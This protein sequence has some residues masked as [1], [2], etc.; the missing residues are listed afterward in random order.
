VWNEDWTASL[1]DQGRHVIKAQGARAGVELALTE[2]KAPAINGIDGISQKGA[3]AGNASHYYSLTRMP[4]RGS[5]S[6][7]GERFEIAGELDGPR[8]RHEL[9]GAGPARMG[10]AVDSAF[11]GG[12]DDHQLRRGDGIVTRVRRH[13]GGQRWAHPPGRERLITPGATF[14][15]AN[16]AVYPIEW[17]I[18]FR[19]RSWTCA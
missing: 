1:D 14:S 5:L 9:P 10:L 12:A 18:V 6:I 17:A 4:T 15:S 2:G 8:V 7:D 13:A 19:R 16:G 11:G 3:Q